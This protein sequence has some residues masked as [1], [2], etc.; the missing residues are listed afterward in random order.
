VSAKTYWVVDWSDT[1][2]PNIIQANEEDEG[3]QSFAAC[4]REIVR[5]ARGRREHWS[6][7]VRVATHAR[8]GQDIY[9]DER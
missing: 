8:K 7:V 6:M 3:A 9:G 1:F 2:F 4:K 5:D